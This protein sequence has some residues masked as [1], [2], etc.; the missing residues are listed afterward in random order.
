MVLQ[1]PPKIQNLWNEWNL[2]GAILTS[3]TFQIILIFLASW[4]KRTGNVIIIALIW[5][6]YLL[7]DWFAAFAVG[8]IT[9]GLTEC[10]KVAE[11]NEILSF[12]APFL[13]LHLGGPDNITAFSLEDNELWLRHLLGLVIQVLAVAYVLSQTLPNPLT[14]PTLLMFFSGTIKYSE[15]TRALYRACLGNFKNSMLPKPDPGPDYAQL[16]DELSGKQIAGVPV[17]IKTPEVPTFTAKQNAE[18]PAVSITVPQSETSGDL[19]K[20]LDDTDIVQYGHKFFLTFK[21]LIVDLMLSFRERNES[22]EFFLNRSEK[23]VF[24]VM[25]VELNL[26]YDVLYT[27]I[28]IVNNLVGYL[29]RV[30]SSACIISSLVLYHLHTVHKQ[31]HKQPQTTGAAP[32]PHPQTTNEFDNRVSYILIAGALA[33]DAIALF[34]IILSDWTVMKLQNATAR[35]IVSWVQKYATLDRYWRWSKRIQNHNL[36]AYCLKRR[37]ELV[38]RA[39]DCIGV[40]EILD[41]MLYA[42]SVPF[43]DKLRDFI[44]R[45]LK[46]KA[47]KGEDIDQAKEIFSGRGDWVLSEAGLSKLISSVD[48]EFDESLLLWHIATELCEQDEAPAGSSEQADEISEHKR[49]SRVLSEYM[50]YLLVMKPTMMSAVAGIGQI[51]YRDT[52]EE[53][54]RFVHRVEQ[55]DLQEMRREACVK[56]LQINTKAAPS[57]V[58]GDKSKSVL[59]DACILAQKLRELEREKRWKVMSKVWV[60]MMAYA[61]S[62]CR[63]NTHAPGNQQGRPAH[64]LYLVVNGPFWVGGAVPNQGRAR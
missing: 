58:K 60:E 23:D 52:C 32:S 25:E 40:S 50:L 2:R 51:R 20:P 36:I 41:Q 54:K 17:D 7:A 57:F 6:A 37:N 61:A 46:A 64:K 21:G 43:D 45:E 4:R 14:I 24:G 8:L 55:N 53:F 11:S 34:K 48:V 29:L 62:H 30:T 12:W 44:V 5:S 56:L 63:A 59:F 13:L 16:M 49:F 9:N 22:R 27:K 35:R 26:M 31:H 28:G 47:R 19:P 10:E 15:R 18:V 38:E 42:T 39:A 33:L 3:L 1:I